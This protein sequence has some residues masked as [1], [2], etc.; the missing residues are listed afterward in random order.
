MRRK[1]KKAGSSAWLLACLL[2]FD[3]SSLHGRKQEKP[4]AVPFAI[5]AGT[6]FRPPGL[7]FPGASV[8]IEPDQVQASG[9]KLKRSDAMTD[10]RGE[11]AI[12]VPAVPSKWTVHVQAKGFGEQSKNVLVEGEQRH[13]LSFQLE[14]VSQKATKGDAR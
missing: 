7:A 14:P 3:P 2:A 8:R 10:S 12:R 1:R 4:A 9:A 11:F 6:V 13:E 5:I